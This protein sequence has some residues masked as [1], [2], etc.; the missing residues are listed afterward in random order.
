[1]LPDEESP[2]EYHSIVIYID[3]FSHQ[4]PDDREIEDEDEERIIQLYSETDDEKEEGAEDESTKQEDN[5]PEVRPETYACSNPGCPMPG[6][7]NDIDNP[8]CCICEGP[9][10]PMDELIAALKAKLKADKAAEKAAAALDGG[11]EEEE[12]EP[13][14]HLRLKMLKRDLRHM[15]S[16]E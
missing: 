4:R 7:E 1:M 3:E 15:I 2:E 14:H 11:E 8:T 16:H 12:D 9:R 6:F 10:P 13:L 5:E